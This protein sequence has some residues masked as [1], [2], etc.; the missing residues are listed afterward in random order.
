MSTPTT[1]SGLRMVD[2]S[3][4]WNVFTDPYQ[5][6]FD[7]SPSYLSSDSTDTEA[8]EPDEYNDFRLSTQKY[9]YLQ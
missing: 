3:H 1:I 7:V 5:G 8:V 2:I 6:A 4:S 9:Q